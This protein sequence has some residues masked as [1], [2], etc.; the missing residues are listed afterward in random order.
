MLKSVLVGGLGAS[1]PWAYLAT[2]AKSWAVRSAGHRVGN[3]ET[4]RNFPTVKSLINDDSNLT[5][6]QSVIAE[7]A[8]VIRDTIS[9]DKR[10]VESLVEWLAL[11]P[12]THQGYGR[13]EAENAPELYELGFSRE[14]IGAVTRLCLG[15]RPDQHRSSLFA[16]F[17]E[18]DHFNWRESRHHRRGAAGVAAVL[19]DTRQETSN[20]P[21]L[22][23]VA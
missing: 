17:L 10:P 12:P 8:Q 1:D 16:A 9:I 22:A 6:L 5:G 19:R 7:T 11:N 15:G 14:E 21:V 23:S 4:E 20:Y 3:L 18:N 13:V 2:C